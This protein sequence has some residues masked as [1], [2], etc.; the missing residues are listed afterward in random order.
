MRCLEKDRTRRYETAN[1]LAKDIQRHLNNEPVLASP[2]S[3]IY[4]LRKLVRRNKPAFAVGT[5]VSAALAMVVIAFFKEFQAGKYGGVEI[6]TYP[7]GAEVWLKGAR[8]GTT[9]Y[10]ATRLTPGKVTYGLKLTNHEPFEAEITIAA[11]KQTAFTFFLDAPKQVPTNSV[12]AFSTYRMGKVVEPL[13]MRLVELQGTVELS[14]KGAT[15]WFQVSLNLLLRPGDRLRT[16]RFSRA[17][18]RWSDGSVV[19]ISQLTELEIIKE[20][21]FL[22]VQA[23][24]YHHA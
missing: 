15:R 8:M 14:A 7:E 4:R 18:L 10:E 3:A 21:P 20:Q 12:S 2:P 19:S 1:G 5:L 24:A 6:N 13:E 9:P 22:K 16:G 17:T 11:R 23:Y